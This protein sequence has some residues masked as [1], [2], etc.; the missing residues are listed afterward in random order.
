MLEQ[1]WYETARYLSWLGD[2]SPYEKGKAIGGFF[3]VAAST[4]ASEGIANELKAAGAT[5][6]AAAAA[7]SLEK[8]VGLSTDAYAAARVGTHSAQALTK[9]EQWSAAVAR[10]ERPGTRAILEKF[11]LEDAY[12]AT[13]RGQATELAKAGW[14]LSEEKL[15]Q[16][17]ARAEDLSNRLPS[18]APKIEIVKVTRGLRKDFVEANM[19]QGMSMTEAVFAKHP[20]M[21]ENVNRM[22]IG[23]DAGI[24]GIYTSD[25]V[26]TAT[27]ELRNNV[28]DIIFAQKE[29]RLEK[30]L[31]LTDAAT[32]ERLGLKS[33]EIST[34]LNRTAKHA[35]ETPQILGL[36]AES[37]GFD[38]IKYDSAQ[39]KA[40]TNWVILRK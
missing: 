24:A 25:S 29:Y 16:I 9:L 18:V 15:M 1:Q 31:D 32:L 35:Y 39:R 21:V 33:D 19:R 30:V 37:N 12:L 7:Q 27:A 3:G 40:G 2:A 14:R 17:S 5:A 28:A 20:S 8:A 23:G 38:A 10:A 34:K 6:E 11:V 26:A 22:T 4:L 13:M 36:L